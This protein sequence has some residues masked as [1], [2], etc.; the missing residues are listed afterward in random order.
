MQMPIGRATLEGLRL[1]LAAKQAEV[2]RKVLAQQEEILQMPEKK[3]KILQR[4]HRNDRMAEA[5]QDMTAAAELG[6][7][8][9]KLATAHRKEFITERCNAAR[10]A[11]TLRNRGE[12][13]GCGTRGGGAQLPV[14]WSLLVRSCD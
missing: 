14:L 6:V 1:K 3:Y 9:A 12:H 7:T 5:R 4:T 8:R 2:R 11:R 10:D 13:E